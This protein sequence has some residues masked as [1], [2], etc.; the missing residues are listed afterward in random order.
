VCVLCIQDYNSD[1]KDEMAA[2]A[3]AAVAGGND[4]D[5]PPRQRLTIAFIRAK[6]V[7]KTSIIKVSL[8]FIY[9]EYKRGLYS[10]LQRS[11]REKKMG[12]QFWN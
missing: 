10:L 4:G 3:A 12:G 6:G 1:L 5:P 9:T 8:P 11:R 7:G 2:A